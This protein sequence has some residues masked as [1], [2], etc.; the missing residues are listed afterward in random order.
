M[1]TASS[2]PHGWIGQARFDQRYGATGLD[3]DFGMHWGPHGN[4]R[5]SLR[6]APDASHGLLYVYDPLWNEYDV[7]DGSVMLEEARAAF[8]WVSRR[9]GSIGVGVDAFV[10]AVRQHRLAPVLAASLE[11]RTLGDLGIEP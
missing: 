1:S 8:D 10:D 6:I 11:P 2:T 7:L 5:V 3:Q 4:Q 9:S